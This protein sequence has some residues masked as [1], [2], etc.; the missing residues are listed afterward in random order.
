MK[1]Y[2]IVEFRRKQWV[3]QLH[4]PSNYQ[5]QYSREHK[6]K[7]RRKDDEPSKL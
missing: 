3:V 2:L 1:M 7:E 4:S 5:Y 6:E